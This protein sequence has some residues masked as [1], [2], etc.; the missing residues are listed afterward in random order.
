MRDIGSGGWGSRG[1]KHQRSYTC[2]EGILGVVEMCFV[3]E[4]VNR[5]AKLHLKDKIGYNKI[6][7]FLLTPY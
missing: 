7:Q 4:I 6:K 1:K 3:K 5:L 2:G